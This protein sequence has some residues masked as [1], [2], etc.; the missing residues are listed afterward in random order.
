MVQDASAQYLNLDFWI[1][2]LIHFILFRHMQ[3]P[4]SAP[5]LRE[6]FGVSNDT[7][8]SIMLNRH[9]STNL[10]NKHISQ[11]YPSP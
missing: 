2:N 11:E 8:T 4:E 6:G 5:P 1:D 10:Y 7:L 9:T 3:L